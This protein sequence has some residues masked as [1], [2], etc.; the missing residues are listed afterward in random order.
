MNKEMSYMSAS[1]MRTE[2][3]R[4]LSS[5]VDEWLEYTKELEMSTK[6]SDLPEKY[7]KVIREAKKDIKKEKENGKKKS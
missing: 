4:K 1:L 2:S 6:L 3:F 5:N 7:R